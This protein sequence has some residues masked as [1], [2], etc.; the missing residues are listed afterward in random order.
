MKRILPADFPAVFALERQCFP[1]VKA[2]LRNDAVGGKIGANSAA[3]VDKISENISVFF[4]IDGD[5]G[6][7]RHIAVFQRV[8][9][10]AG[11]VQRFA[12]MGYAGLFPFQLNHGQV[13]HAA[14]V[15]I[16]H[17][18]SAIIAGV[19][20]EFNANVGGSVKGFAP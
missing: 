13:S 16:G 1:K 2:L 15:G 6:P 11:A 8:E 9:F 7:F 12:A 18:H 10:F 4:K 14:E 5:G 3:C 19:C 17:I 20:F